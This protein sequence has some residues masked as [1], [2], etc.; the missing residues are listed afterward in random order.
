MK[1]NKEVLIMLMPMLFNSNDMFDLTPFDEMDRMFDSFF[2]GRTTGNAAAMRT[3]VLEEDKDYRLSAELPGFNKE[4]IKIGLENGAL[5][6]SASHKE[7]NSEKNKEGKYIRRE[8]S[9]SS[10]QRSFRVPDDLKPEDIDASYK[11]GVLTVILPKKEVIPAKEAPKQI[12]I[13]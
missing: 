11:D 5:T 7:D 8:R 6:I 12:E 3:D 9:V 13:K 2:G 1:N 4:D 10:Y